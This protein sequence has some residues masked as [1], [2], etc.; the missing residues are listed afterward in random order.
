MRDGRMSESGTDAVCVQQVYAESSTKKKKVAIYPWQGASHSERESVIME[1]DVGTEMRKQADQATLAHYPCL[2]AENAQ[3]L[4][5]LA[6]ADSREQA[7]QVAIKNL[8]ECLDK[9][10]AKVAVLES[11]QRKYW[12]G[13]TRKEF[14]K[15][16]VETRRRILARQVNDLLDAQA[17]QDKGMCE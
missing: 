8:K 5:Q 11:E 14:L 17:M 10:E 4:K 6:E 9:A 15:L 3:L 12:D 1:F 16:P 7:L 13:M 2:V